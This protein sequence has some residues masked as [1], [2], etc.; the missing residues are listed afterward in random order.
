MIKRKT[1]ENNKMM[2]ISNER[3]IMASQ[4]AKPKDSVARNT[5]AQSMNIYIYIHIH[6]EP[7]GITIERKK[8]EASH[9]TQ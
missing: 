9:I 4:N 8:N 2:Y 3:I 1:A 5:D 6:I 7:E